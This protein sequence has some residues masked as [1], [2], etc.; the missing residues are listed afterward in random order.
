M[1]AQ[2]Y[3]RRHWSATALL[4]SSEQC[5]L[6]YANIGLQT[7]MV[8]GKHREEHL[9][10]LRVSIMNVVRATDLDILCM[11][12]VGSYACTNIGELSEKEMERVCQMCCD[13]WE[14]ITGARPG[15]VYQW[16]HPYLTL[17]NPNTIGIKKAS[18]VPTFIASAQ[19]QRFAQALCCAVHDCQPFDVWNIHNPCPRRPN[20][21]TDKQRKESLQT[22]LRTRSN[23]DPRKTTGE[24]SVV[25]G[26]D[27]NI[28]YE[29]MCTL[30]GQLGPP[31]GLTWCNDRTLI[32]S[33]IFRPAQV[34]KN[35]SRGT[36]GCARENSPDFCMACN[37]HANTIN[38]QIEFP[39]EST[40]H[41]PYG[42]LITCEPLSSTSRQE[43]TKLA[44]TTQDGA[45]RRNRR[46]GQQSHIDADTRGGKD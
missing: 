30:M 7:Q 10:T 4:R 9:R 15:C 28:N 38:L 35:Y 29:M 20:N 33:A 2:R 8:R 45:H 5:V 39:I 46:W 14:S 22:I 34:S 16:P 31:L 13:A 43:Q 44:R 40:A 18:I 12:E 36:Q 25:I 26:G 3:R 27:M 42:I 32:Q 11:C 41:I 37:L 1:L 17:Y 23:T 19:R 24:G 6:I 21:L